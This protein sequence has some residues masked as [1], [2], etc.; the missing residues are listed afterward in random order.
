MQTNIH[1]HT[2]PSWMSG[3]YSYGCMLF[4]LYNVQ[5]NDTSEHWVQTHTISQCCT[6]I[7]G[8]KSFNCSRRSFKYC[9]KWN[10][11][12]ANFKFFNLS[13]GM[14]T[15]PYTI[16]RYIPIHPHSKSA[17]VWTN[18]TMKMEPI[19][20]TKCINLFESVTFSRIHWNVWFSIVTN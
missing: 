10:Y 6:I 15:M 12:W 3:W 9:I 5:S 17:T 16:P 7:T 13:S 18:R 11:L 19:S 20:T 8:R 4:Q 14:C 1:T 2:H